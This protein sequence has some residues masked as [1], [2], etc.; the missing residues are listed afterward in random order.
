MNTEELADSRETALRGERQREAEIDISWCKLYVPRDGKVRTRHLRCQAIVHTPSTPGLWPRVPRAMTCHWKLNRPS[1]PVGPSEPKETNPKCHRTEAENG[2]W[3]EKV[4]D[5]VPSGLRRGWFQR[6]SRN[7]SFKMLGPRP[8]QGPSDAPSSCSDREQ[9]GPESGHQY[10]I[11]LRGGYSRA[12]RTRPVLQRR[13]WWRQDRAVPAWPHFPQGLSSVLDAGRPTAALALALRRWGGGFGLTP[14]F[15]RL[16]WDVVLHFDLHV[17]GFQ[18]G[19]VQL[20][21]EIWHACW[22]R[23]QSGRADTQTSRLTMFSLF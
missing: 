7:T 18:S 20:L 11:S 22:E 8:W 6:S 16:R 10:W 12:L 14:H 17:L 19:H 5:V 13:E 15:Q 23:G 4:K 9:Q 2:M 3:A 21:Q 1:G